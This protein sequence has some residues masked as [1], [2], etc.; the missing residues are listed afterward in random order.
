MQL[1]LWKGDES[2][3]EKIDVVKVVKIAATVMSVAGMLASGWAGSKENEKTL[4]K[5]VKEHFATK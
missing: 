4:E 2:K 5:L 3:M 1:L